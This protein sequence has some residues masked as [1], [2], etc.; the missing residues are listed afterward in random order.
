MDLS[1][2]LETESMLVETVFWLK[3]QNGE[4]ETQIKRA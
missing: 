1:V 3:R 2:A 4:R